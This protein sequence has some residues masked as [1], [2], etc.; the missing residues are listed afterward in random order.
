MFLLNPAMQTTPIDNYAMKMEVYLDETKWR[1]DIGISHKIIVCPSRFAI[2][3][4]KN[5]M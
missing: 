5:C 3:G 4:E 1:K 2:R